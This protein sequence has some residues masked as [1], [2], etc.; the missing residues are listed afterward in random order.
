[1]FSMWKKNN[2]NKKCRKERKNLV[3]DF[4]HGN[5]N[6]NNH[7]ASSDHWKGLAAIISQ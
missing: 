1:M 2:I 7:F 3:N 4:G 6:M 5:I